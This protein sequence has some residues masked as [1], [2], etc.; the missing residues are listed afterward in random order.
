MKKIIALIVLSCVI[1]SI[2][3]FTANAAQFKF[4]DVKTTDWYYEDVKFA[5][6]RGLINGKGSTDTYLAN[7]YLTYGEAIKLA[8]C[9]NQLYM[10]GAITLKNGT[11]WYQTYVDYC[12]KN[13]IIDKEYIYDQNA[14]RSGYMTIFAKALPDTALK[15]INTVKDNS[16]PDVSLDTRYG[17]AVYKLYRAGIVAG[18]DDAHNCK[19]YDN[20]KRSEVA[21]I[22]SR[23]M[24]ETKRVKFSLPKIVEYT[25]TYE[26][27]GG[28]MSGDRVQKYDSEA[29]NVTLPTPSYKSYAEY[30]HFAGWYLDKNLTHPYTSENFNATPGNVTLYAKWDLCT[31][32]NSIDNTPDISS[33]RVIA[34]WRNDTDTNILNHPNRVPTGNYNTVNIYSGTKEV[35]FIGNPNKTY[36]N[37]NINLC[38]FSRGQE[39]TIKF[40]DFNF[41]SNTKAAITVSDDNG[42][43]LTI[44][45]VGRCYIN[46]TYKAGSIIGTSDTPL[47][48]ITFKGTGSLNLVAGSGVNATNPGEN[49]EDGGVAIYAETINMNMNMTG[50]VIVNGG[51]GGNG[52]NGTDGKMGTPSYN[53][54]NDRNALSNGANGGNGGDGTNGSDGGKGGFAYSAKFINMYSGKLTAIGGN[55]GNGGN[56]GN[57]GKGGKGQESGGWG[58][59]AGNGGNGGKAGN[60]GNTYIV[61]ASNGN[62]VV[63]EYGGTLNR[64]KGDKG[65]VGASGKKGEAG[66]RGMHC[67]NENCGQWLTSGNDGRN[68]SEGEAG[69]PGMVYNIP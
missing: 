26:L 2:A 22:V 54:H 39:L 66:A 15:S 4:K 32:F 6:E 8:A 1:T 17:E 34:D 36:N 49:G 45:V 9:M 68:G 67:D 7:D 50:S 31:E 33:G 47:K 20:I 13:G 12:F 23:M 40:V 44:D 11:P 58:S 59:T 5:V 52:V 63:T 30:N 48:D 60:G 35:I 55:S 25:I 37:L 42:V 62:E 21:A 41:T 56:G 46:T 51:N 28:T 16:I 61:A 29:L 24:N 38:Q 3:V 69:T 53:G 65:L 64:L 19:P 18:S 43:H 10:E 14:T 27:N 57:G